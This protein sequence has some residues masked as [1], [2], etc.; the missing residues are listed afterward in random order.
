MLAHDGSTQEYDAAE[1]EQDPVPLGEPA[2][3]SRTMS[4]YEGYLCEYEDE[5]DEYGWRTY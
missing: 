5:E 2:G 4:G 1:N 3:C